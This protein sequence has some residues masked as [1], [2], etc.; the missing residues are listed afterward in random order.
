M[1]KATCLPQELAIEMIPASPENEK[2]RLLTRWWGF[3]KALL[4]RLKAKAFEI[5]FSTRKL[6]RDDPRRV[7]HSAKVG[8]ALTLVSLVYL[9]QPLYVNFGVSAMWAIV[10]VVVVF[11]FTVGKFWNIF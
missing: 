8:V 11:E 10:T 1:Q 4:E 6:A 9:Y 5:A 3:L 2:E 7:I